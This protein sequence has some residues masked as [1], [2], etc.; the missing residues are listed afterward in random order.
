MRLHSVVA[1][2]GLCFAAFFLFA[3]PISAQVD[4][5]DLSGTVLDRSGAVIPG[6]SVSLHNTDTGLVRTAVTDVHGLYRFVA[7]PVVGHYSIEV[8]AKGFVVETRTGL[9]FQATSQPVE[10]FTLGVGNTTQ[11]VTVSSQA[12]LVET[13][14]AQLGSTVDQARIS[15]MPLNGRNYMALGLLTTGVHTSALRGDLSFNG[16][17]GRNID[18]LVDGVSNKVNEWGDASAVGLSLDVVQEFQVITNQFSAEFGHS[19]GGVVSVVTKS[20]TDNFHGTTYLYDRPG[21]LDADN[22]LSHVQTPFDQQQFGGVLSG[23]IIKGK[24]HFIGGYEGT[25]QNSQ[26]TVTSPVQPGNFPVWLHR[27][28]AFGKVTH[29]ITPNETADVRFNYDN[30]ESIGGFGGLVLPSG[31]TDAQRR[32]WDVQGTITSVLSPTTVNEGRFQFQRFLNQ[33]TDLSGGPESVYLGYATFGAN[34]S[35]PQDIH[36]DRIQFN[37][38]LSHNFG[39]HEFFAG[40]DFSRIS[41]TGV[42]NADSMGVYT[43]A[44]GTPYPFDP[45]DPA[46]FPISF[47]QGFTSPLR[48]LNL[49]RDYAPYH[50]AG[51]NRSY[52]D[53]DLYA[54]DQ[55]Q[56]TRNFTLNLGVRYQKQTDSP[57][58]DNIMAR[59]GFAW[60]PGTSGRLVIRGGYGRFYDQLIDNVPNDS[61]LFGLIGNFNVTLTPGGNPGLFPTYPDIFSS[62]PSGLG[63]AP[64]RSVIL[65]L[66][67]LH[68]ALEQ[69]PYSDQF[70]V[71]V[72]DQ[73]SANLALSVDYVYLRGSD[74]F[75]TLDFNSPSFFDTSTG[76]IRTTT[77]ANATRPYGV[78]SV[79]PGPF[80]ISDGGFEQIQGVVSQGSSRYDGI[81][82][83]LNKRFSNHFYYQVAYTWSR[84]RS[85]QD[86]FGDLPFST[87]SG[88]DFPW[89]RSVNDVPENLVMNG[90][91]QLP[92]GFSYSGIF[93][94]Y[95]GL[96]VNPLAGADLNGD[97]YFN[98]RPGT[99]ER[100]SFRIGP[101]VDLDSAIAKTIRLK[102]ENTLVLRADVFNTLNRE[103]VTGVNN[104]YG[105]TPGTPLVTFLTPT[106]TLNPREFQF[107]VRYSF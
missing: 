24:T 19:L 100:N 57:S 54:Q 22:F 99:F 80:G 48:P 94:A 81:K 58:N 27:Q 76:A 86:D 91:Y 68:P 93:S 69:T 39:K 60:S 16:Q 42:Y 12:P 107:S 6:A 55:W 4:N 75:R 64:G 96:P 87:A 63:P 25:R 70:S 85:T 32:G 21:D 23:P 92:W 17:L 73:L 105:N 88:V 67:A 37:D 62:A 66:G 53:P 44:A 103:N 104:T 59:T 31:G 33:S 83:N 102:R 29:F 28:E 89:G 8:Q 106:K 50:F 52:W 41:K 18:Y 98:D 43:F 30:S 51:I 10:N 9:V 11:S 82:V 5:F 71:G 61:D 97:T 84:A 45:A 20:G 7:L 2:L 74:L 35:S 77:Q 36:E 15:S 95:A 65:D 3:V 13:Q 40:T 47:V 101:Q 26:L 56:I 90:E 14:K 49:T 1:F 46:T 79:T 34:P 72:A 78:P 38:K